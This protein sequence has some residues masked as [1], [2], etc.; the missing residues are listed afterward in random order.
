MS[1]TADGKMTR[2]P[3]G[4]AGAKDTGTWKLDKTASAP[5]G[6]APSPIASHRDRRR[7][8]M[9]GDEGLGRDRGVEQVTLGDSEANSGD[10][11]KRSERALTNP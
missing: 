7:E 11:A 3:A 6:R 1:F 8:Q 4:K 9:V 5:R 10:N 2:E